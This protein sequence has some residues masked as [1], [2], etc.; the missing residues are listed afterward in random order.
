MLPFFLFFI[1]D[2]KFGCEVGFLH[3]FFM[4]ENLGDKKESYSKHSIV[5]NCKNYTYQPNGCIKADFH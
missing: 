4:V 1:Q 2:E 5:V 3:C